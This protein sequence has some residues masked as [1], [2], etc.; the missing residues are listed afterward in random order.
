MLKY[1]V[2]VIASSPADALATLELAK[3]NKKLHTW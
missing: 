1:D 2:I 3:N